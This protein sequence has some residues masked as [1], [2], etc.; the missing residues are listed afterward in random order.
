MALGL[1]PPSVG[2]ESRPTGSLPVA[3]V[4]GEQGSAPLQPDIQEPPVGDEYCQTCHSNHSLTSGF[5]N[6]QPL[7]LYVDPRTLRDSSHN[8]VSCVTCHDQLGAHPAETPKTYDFAVYRTEAVEM[9][10][11]CH[12]AAVS[13][14]AQSAHWEQTFSRDEGATCID[15]HSP[16]GSGHSIPAINDR[17]SGLG[18][19]RVGDVCGTCHQQALASYDGTSHG[20]VARF[21]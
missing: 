8:L 6:G 12:E 16:G 15:C 18:P 1:Q 11:R 21:G 17:L 3:S 2:G 13:G 5:T 7:S 19:A 4:V 20:K 10:T 14:Y 9:C